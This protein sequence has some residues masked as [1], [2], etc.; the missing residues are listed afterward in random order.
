LENNYHVV[1]WWN[2][3]NLNTFQ[4][5]IYMNNFAMS[6]LSTT[7]NKFISLLCFVYTIRPSLAYS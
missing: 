7:E 1:K 3:R 4:L 6:H 5:Q 2:T